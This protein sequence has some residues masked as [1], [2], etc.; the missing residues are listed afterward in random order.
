MA[1]LTRPLS[2]IERIESMDGDMAFDDIDIRSDVSTVT[3]QFSRFTVATQA[4]MYS[5][6][7]SKYVEQGNVVLLGLHY[8]TNDYLH[9]MSA[10][11]RRRAEK[12]SKRGGKKGSIEEEE[13][14]LQSMTKIV[15]H[16]ELLRQGAWDVIRALVHHG[17]EQKAGV[18]QDSCKRFETELQQD[19]TEIFARTAEP[20]D[21]KEPQYPFPRTF[22]SAQRPVPK[23]PTP[24][25]KNFEWK[26]RTI[27]GI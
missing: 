15:R 3:S 21:A 9:R 8:V 18:L 16:Y 4:S 5:D 25:L 17:Y 13:Y 10:G 23:V 14:L 24:S 12:K 6:S 2:L 11:S 19:V 22:T 20:L 27:G 7:S 26:L 1:S